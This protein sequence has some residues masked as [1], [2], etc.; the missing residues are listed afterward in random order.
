MTGR[1]PLALAVDSDAAALEA[2]RRALRAQGLRVVTATTGADALRAAEQQHPNLVL[3]STRL[4]DMSGLEAMRRLRARTSIPVILVSADARMTAA[5]AAKSGM[6][7]K[8]FSARQL[9]DAV[10]EAL[11]AHAAP[12]RPAATRVAVEGLDIDLVARTVRRGGATVWLTRTEWA[13]LTYL[14]GNPGRALSGAEI[15]SS[16]W[17]P[18]YRDDLQYLRVWVSRL[19]SKL[20][21]HEARMIIRTVRGLGYV[22]DPSGAPEQAQRPGVVRSAARSAVRTGVGATATRPAR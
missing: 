17:G 22:F 19:R 14:A 15:L 20:G 12:R 13:L 21:A 2:S 3:L 8:R 16:V 1:A 9:A 5:A 4:S 6:L 11:A 10:D 7:P 18:E